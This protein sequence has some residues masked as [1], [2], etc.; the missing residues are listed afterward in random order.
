MQGPLPPTLR[1]KIVCVVQIV[2]LMLAIAPP[3]E[4]P[5]SS[6]VA[7]AGLAVLSYSFWVDTRRLWRG[8][9]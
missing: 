6:I 5:A 3:I 7:A 1:A 9:Q 2:A 4:R 8:T